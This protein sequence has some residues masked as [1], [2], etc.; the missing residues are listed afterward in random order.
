M[1]FNQITLGLSSGLMNIRIE[2]NFVLFPEVHKLLRIMIR[3][4]KIRL[5]TTLPKNF[6][7]HFLF[8]ICSCH[9]SYVQAALTV[10]MESVDEPN[11]MW[12]LTKNLGSR[13]FFYD[14]FEPY[15]KVLCIRCLRKVPARRPFK[16]R[17]CIVGPDQH[18]TSRNCLNTNH[19]QLTRSWHF[20]EKLLQSNNTEAIKNRKF[21]SRSLLKQFL[22]PGKVQ[23]SNTS[24]WLASFAVHQ[25]N[26][27]SHK[28][29]RTATLLKGWG[30]T[31]KA[32]KNKTLTLIGKI[33]NSS[34][35]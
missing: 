19:S 14:V 16:G 20:L 29:Q 1:C 22:S 15:T 32:E 2:K 13:H 4:A 26:H 24:S 5:E 9:C 27:F 17:G 6:A 23:D 25:F 34:K 12:K 10:I 30:K 3:V 11:A 35:L 28:K 7:L 33:Y 8:I 18:F 21:E 31:A